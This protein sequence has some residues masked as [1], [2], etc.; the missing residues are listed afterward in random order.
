MKPPILR[1]PPA[2]LVVAVEAREETDAVL[3][4]GFE[5]S[6][7]AGVYGPWPLVVGAAVPFVA[8]LELVEGL[9]D[10]VD[11][12][13]VEV[14]EGVEADLA[15][16]GE[17]GVCGS[18]GTGFCTSRCFSFSTGAF[19]AETGE[20]RDGRSIAGAGDGFD[21]VIFAATAIEREG[22]PFSFAGVGSAVGARVEGSGADFCV[23]G[24]S[25]AFERAAAI[26]A[27]GEIGSSTRG[28]EGFAGVGFSVIFSAGCSVVLVSGLAFSDVGADLSAFVSGS[29][30]AVAKF[31]TLLITVSMGGAVALGSS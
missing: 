23:F 18:S 10:W 24:V 25:S 14:F 17:V 26:F 21:G 27:R 11:L 1:V 19:A 16:A 2:V 22:V 29:L 30:F 3:S 20:G 8:A 13:G 6:R 5:R 4:R 9:E 15:G 31:R 12:A 28:C 7:F